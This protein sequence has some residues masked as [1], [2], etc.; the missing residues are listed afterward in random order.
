MSSRR[1]SIIPLSGR[2]RQVSLYWYFYVFGIRLWMATSFYEL[3]RELW[4]DWLLWTTKKLHCRSSYINSLL[5]P[6]N[7]W[8]HTLERLK[9]IVLHSRLTL[10]IIYYIYI[11]C[12][13]YTLMAIVFNLATTPPLVISWCEPIVACCENHII[14]CY[15][16]PVYD[17][18][19][20]GTHNGRPFADGIFLIHFRNW[21]SFYFDSNYNEVFP[22]G[23]IWQKSVLV[24]IMDWCRTG[25]KPLSE[26]TMV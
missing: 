21:N 8:A 9:L 25:N 19:E 14:N 7:H 20:A 16:F 26:P 11:Y 2:Y 13:Q 1:Q 10:S 3:L 18:I 6:V 24:Q 17:D 15:A 22:C 23:S 12:R 5:S 4:T